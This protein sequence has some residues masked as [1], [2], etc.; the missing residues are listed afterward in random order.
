VTARGAARRYAPG[1][2]VVGLI[3]AGFYCY[4]LGSGGSFYFKLVKAPFAPAIDAPY[5]R[6]SILHVALAHWLGLGTSILG[7]RLAVLSCLWAAWGYL[8]M[9]VGRRL[10]VS[11]TCLVLLV[12]MAHPAAMIAYAWTCHPDALTYLLTAVLMFTRRPWVV[13]VVAALGAWT[14]LAIWGLVCGNAVILWF[15]FAEARARA[16]AVAAGVGLVVGAGTGALALHLWGIAIA[17]DRLALG[18]ASGLD[19]LLG[20]WT[21][22]GWPIIYSLHFAHLLW[23]P[24]LLVMLLRSRRAGAFALLLTQALALTAACFTQ[25]TTRV[26]AFLAWGPLVYC[27]VYALDEARG[28]GERR[29]L[30]PLVGVAVLVTLV[31]PKVFAWKGDLRDTEGA[32]AQLRGLLF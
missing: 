17:R 32:R 27:L 9:V 4:G 11:D 16:R 10:S 22:V 13:A 2:V 7:F 25:D 31:A 1:L 12:L 28:V 8:A 26:F 19:V 24:V 5:Y 15:A 20:Y 23:L 21:G 3:A 29:Y 14:H 30:R 6:A 18:M